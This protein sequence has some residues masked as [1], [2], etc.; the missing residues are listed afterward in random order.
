MQRCPFC[1]TENEAGAIWC[2]QCKRD[3]AGPEP[4]LPSTVVLKNVP[5]VIT[6]PDAEGIPLAPVADTTVA[7]ESGTGAS[8]EASGPASDLTVHEDPT[9]IKAGGGSPS[10]GTLGGLISRKLEPKLVV[11]RGQ[12]VNAQ[13]IIRAGKNYIGRHDDRPVDINLDDQEAP[14]K[15]WSSRQHAVISFEGGLLTVEDLNSL[16]GTFVNRQRV[17]PGQPRTL[18][19]GDILQIGTVQLKV[20]I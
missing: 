9:H 4:T 16:N 5:K 1:Q 20:V 12:H 10:S 6:L 14:D 11:V 3:L 19:V 8:G 2:H 18:N 13:F 17:N 7:G 15:V